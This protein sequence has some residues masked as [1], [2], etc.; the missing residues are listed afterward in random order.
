MAGAGIG[1]MVF[2]RDDQQLRD[3]N[4]WLLGSLGGITWDR[5][6]LAAPFV[7]AGAALLPFYARPLTALL[8]GESEAVH[9]GFH[10][11]R[12]KRA[13]VVLAALVTANAGAITGVLAFVGI[14]LPPLVPLVP[15]PDHRPPPARQGVGSVT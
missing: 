6:A 2:L 13:D 1:F 11:E 9:L 14:V 10:V 12:S 4:Y 8:L 5:L 3:L 15:G 7:L